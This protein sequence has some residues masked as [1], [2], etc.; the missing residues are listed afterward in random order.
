MLDAGGNAVDAAVA[1]AAVLAVVTPHLSGLG[2]DCVALV[3]LAGPGGE[4]I[5]LDGTG[6]APAGL[7]AQALREAGHRRMPRDGAHAVTVPGAVAAWCHMHEHWGRLDLAHVLAPAIRHGEG[8]VP[9][10]PRVALDW[11]LGLD[12]LAPEGR[13]AF[14]PGAITPEPGRVHAAPGLA[15][16][17]RRIASGGAAGFYRGEVAE[18]MVATLAGAGG[19][20]VAQDFAEAR[21]IPSRPERTGHGDLCLLEPAPN[22]QAATTLL[23]AN[24]LDRFDISGNHP[25]DP[26]RTHLEIEVTRHAFDTRDRA[27][28]R[29]DQTGQAAGLLSRDLAQMLADLIDDR[30]T[31]P[32]VPAPMGAEHRDTASLCIVDRDLISVTMVLSNFRSFGS[33]LVSR[34]FGILLNSR[35]AAFNLEPGHPDEAAGGRAPRRADVPVMIREPGRGMT[36]LAAGGGDFQPVGHARI[37]G[38]LAEYGMPL[39]KAVDSPRCFWDNGEV[40]MEKSYTPAVAHELRFMGHEVTISDMP[41]GG[42]QAIRIDLETGVFEGASDPRQDGCALGL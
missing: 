13:A 40:V 30:E 11:S 27:L 31:G 23:L 41:L 9:L 25:L 36:L 39:Q 20:H 15:E 28:A 38:N 19:S 1:A 21:A 24:I 29:P 5:S 18:D 10:A 37:L 16:V 34:E 42:A 4:V 14:L 7:S 17:L 2:G 26:W 22:G 8:G 3:S 33:G 32:G 12:H 35:A 6:R